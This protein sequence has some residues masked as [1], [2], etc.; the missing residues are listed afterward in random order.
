LIFSFISP[1]SKSSSVVVAVAI[2]AETLAVAVA[3]TAETLLVVA[4]VEIV[5]NTCMIKK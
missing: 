3:I 4:V 5:Q 2:T 1:Y